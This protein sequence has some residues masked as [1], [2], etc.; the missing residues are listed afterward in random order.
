MGDPEPGLHRLDDLLDRRHI[1]AVAGEQLV[2]HRHPLPAHDQGDADLLAVGP[3][4]AAVAPLGEG[5]ADGLAFK[6]GA[7]HIVEEQVV[8][9]G[10][11]LPEAGDEVLLEGG[12]VGEELVQGAVEP[13]VIDARRGQRQQ[14]LEG[15]APIPVLGDMQLARGL[16]QPGQDQH[17]RHGGPRHRLAPFG[18]QAREHRIEP[19]GAP[20]GPA[21]PHVAERAAAFEPDVPQAYRHCRLGLGGREQVGLLAVAGDGAGQRAGLGAPSGVQ[22]PELRDGVL[23]DLA[24]HAHRADQ[25]PV[26][27]D[28]A[29]LPPRRMA[30]VHCPVYALGRARKSMHL[31]GTTRTVP[32]PGVPRRALTPRHGPKPGVA[33][34]E[35]RKL[36]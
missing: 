35:L 21:K 9:E 22:L 27:V 31:V 6:V 25:P 4:I 12:L 34:L 3:M 13:V 5:I 18:Q 7:G 17:R 32:G 14:I 36:G 26:A 28:L 8:V 10:E 1:R 16:A 2:A 20:Q 30:Q 19:Q 23:H 24:A 29:V 15:G 11:Q 33:P